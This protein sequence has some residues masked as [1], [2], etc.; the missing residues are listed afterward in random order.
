[1]APPSTTAL[2]AAQLV[3]RRRAEVPLKPASSAGSEVQ[4]EDAATVDWEDG[5]TVDWES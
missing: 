4:W 1:M 5:T 3:A 2:T